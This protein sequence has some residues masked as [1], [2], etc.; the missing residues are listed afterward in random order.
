M[1]RSR[2]AISWCYWTR[3]LTHHLQPALSHT[4]LA[5]ARGPVEEEEGR[6]DHHH[7]H[8]SRITNSKNQIR[9]IYLHTIAKLYDF[10]GTVR[11]D[12]K[13]RLEEALQ[14]LRGDSN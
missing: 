11:L 6:G 12:V 8:S 13:S 1:S 9:I 4:R 3:V 2:T 14:P 10:S 7:T 5:N